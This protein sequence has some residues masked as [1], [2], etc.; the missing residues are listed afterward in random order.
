M[1]S[2]MQKP[3]MA[4]SATIHAVSSE[5]ELFSRT[6]VVVTVE[7][8]KATF[9]HTTMMLKLEWI[10]QSDRP[11]WLIVLSLIS[12]WTEDTASVV[13]VI[14]GLLSYYERKVPWGN[15]KSFIGDS[16][17]FVQ[18][19][20]VFIRFPFLAY[21]TTRRFVLS[22]ICAMRHWDTEPEACWCQCRN[23]IQLG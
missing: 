8:S 1:N 17:E 19:S 5:S 10:R 3:Q 23:Y 9:V 6:S 4:H 7:Y 21:H 12:S 16:T 20:Y 2:G 15:I 13:E 14:L 18:S 11:V 22:W